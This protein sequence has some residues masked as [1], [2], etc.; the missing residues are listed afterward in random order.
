MKFALTNKLLLTASV[1]LTLGTS[2]AAPITNLY[3]PDL[4]VDEIK[5]YD[6]NT[7]QSD[8]KYKVDGIDIELDEKDL[9]K[10]KNWNLTA[11]QWAQY[12]Y[13]M[14]YTPRETWSPD[15]EPTIVLGLLAKRETEKMH[16]ANLANAMELDRRERGITLQQYGITDIKQR[17]GVSEFGEEELTRIEQSLGE[18]K[19]G[20][21]SIFVDP[22]EGACDKQCVR[23]LLMTMMGTPSNQSIVVYHD[24]GTEDDVYAMFKLAGINRHDLDKKEAQVIYSKEKFEKYATNP[25]GIPFYIRV[26]DTGEYRKEI[27]RKNKG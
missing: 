25:N 20:I 2:H 8:V 3:V 7:K 6:P 5:V 22:T 11:S 15:L 13:A 16:Y 1:A 18:T 23:F 19:T 12:K 21:K 24:K 9:V 14:E 4:S 10:A 26:N 27:K 17:M